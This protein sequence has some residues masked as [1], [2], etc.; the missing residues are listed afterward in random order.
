MTDNTIDRAA[1]KRMGEGNEGCAVPE[2]TEKPVIS[3][4][5][6]ATE[7]IDGQGRGQG[8][9][10]LARRSKRYCAKHGEAKFAGLV[11]AH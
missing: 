6:T 11:K 2:C 4:G 9:R 1:F 10:M 3:I 7:I 8:S 5:L